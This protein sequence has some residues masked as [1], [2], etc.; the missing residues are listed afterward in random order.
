MP[1]PQLA[2]LLPRPLRE[3]M[4]E[5][6]ALPIELQGVRE[7]KKAPKADPKD[8]SWL[9]EKKDRFLGV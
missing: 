5:F 9:Y 4:R 1:L 6:H 7:L 3:K 8:V 2:V